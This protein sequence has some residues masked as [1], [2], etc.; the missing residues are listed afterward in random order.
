MT[1]LEYLGFGYSPVTTIIKMGHYA[2]LRYLDR[3]L[4]NFSDKW[5]KLTAVAASGLLLILLSGSR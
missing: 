4:K 2:T 1:L 3:T 5:L